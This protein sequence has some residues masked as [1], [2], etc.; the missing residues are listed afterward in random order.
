MFPWLLGI[1]SHVS[2]FLL[3]NSPDPAKC[4][5]IHDYNV[6][7]ETTSSKNMSLYQRFRILM[8]KN[9]RLQYR[10]YVRSIFEIVVPIVVMIL[11]MALRTVHE[12]ERGKG[13]IYDSFCVFPVPGAECNETENEIRARFRQATSI[14]SEKAMK[15]V[16][17]QV[18][19]VGILAFAAKANR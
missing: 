12:Y 18:Q 19:I 4:V 15:C 1:A 7:S 13:R 5:T 11:L 8:W 10:H 2:V 14:T 17:L 16:I 6:K 3:S 9:F